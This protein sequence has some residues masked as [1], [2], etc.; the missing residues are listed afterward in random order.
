MFALKHTVICDDFSKGYYFPE[1]STLLPLESKVGWL[2]KIDA[3]P[4]KAVLSAKRQ[5]DYL[6]K[7]RH[8]TIGSY[9]HHFRDSISNSIP[10]FS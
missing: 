5:T 6:G 1:S 10:C 2:N 8:H 9:G 4:L 3:I 7:C